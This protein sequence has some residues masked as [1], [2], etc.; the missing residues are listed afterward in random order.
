DPTDIDVNVSRP[1]AMAQAAQDGLQL[2]DQIVKFGDVEY[3]DNLLPKLASKPQKNQG[4]HV[5]M[6]VMKQGTSINLAVKPRTWHRRGLLGET[7]DMLRK[8]LKLIGESVT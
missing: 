5:L 4:C 2:R 7:Y 3:G 1:F 6:L 8:K